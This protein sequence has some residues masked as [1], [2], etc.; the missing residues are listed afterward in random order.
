MRAVKKA[1]FAI[2]LIL[3]LAPGLTV[4]A[5]G[6]RLRPNY[7]SLNEWAR[8]NVFAAHWIERDKTLE[9]TGRGD[10]LVFNV[11]SRSDARRAQI[12]GVQVW[13]AFPVLDQNGSVLISQV[14][15]ADTLGPIL[16][17]PRIPRGINIRTICL[18]PGHGGKDPGNR[19]GSNEE[20]KYTLLLAQEAAAQ[21]RVLGFKVY[22]TRS[23]DTFVDLP[24]RPEIA[25]RRGADLFV[26]LHFNSTEEARN[27]VRGVEI[28]CCS[29]AGATSTN[30]RGEGDTRWVVGNRNDEK[31]MLLAYEMQRA[32]GKNLAVEDRGVKR[33]RFQ[34]LREA[35][36]PAIL[37][38]GG[39]MSHPSEGK[40]I[41]DPAY[42]KQMAR[43]IVNGILGYKKVVTR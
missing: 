38:E 21:L 27:E 40:K 34:V 2:L 24:M 17:P 43:A 5:S 3:F 31:N 33:A 37:I 36:M 13:L 9:L 8:A 23:S 22:L 15:L 18:D 14:D 10:R 1:A 42:R 28:F 6:A 25:R 4:S 41:Y 12:N 7:V 35:T 11:D 26:S 19:A 32:Y 39:F 29:P 30:A 20:K 16:S